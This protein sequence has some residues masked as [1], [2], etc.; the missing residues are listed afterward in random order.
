MLNNVNYDW[1]KQFKPII[2]GEVEGWK[3]YTNDYG[4]RD[5][6]D[7]KTWSD[8]RQSVVVIG[9]SQ[10]FGWGI[11]YEHTFTH[12][13]EQKLGRQVVNLGIPAVSFDTV[14]LLS[15]ELRKRYKPWSVVINWPDVMRYREWHT[16]HD[17]MLTRPVMNRDNLL[18]EFYLKS[19]EFKE[20]IAM[21]Q[22]DSTDLMWSNQT[23]YFSISWSK[24]VGHRARQF[25]KIDKALDGKH[26]GP[27]TH[28]SVCDWLASQLSDPY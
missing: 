12:L 17:C 16:G 8:F 19:P 15:I 20:K 22:M 27:K 18:R 14:W 10:T 25:E 1:L 3:V 23:K 26:W 7:R 5:T 13:L 11:D 24:S 4:F 28:A 21:S 9:C 6:A 2:T